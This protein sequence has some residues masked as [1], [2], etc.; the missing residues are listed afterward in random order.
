MIPVIEPSAINILSGTQKTVHDSD[1]ISFAE[2]K[3]KQTRWGKIKFWISEICEAIMPAV[4]MFV[5]LAG[6][7]AALLNAYRNR[8]RRTVFAC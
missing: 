5:S 3:P 7:T 2:A 6:A 8:G 4:K 1:T